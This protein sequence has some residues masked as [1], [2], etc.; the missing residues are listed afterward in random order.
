MDEK[1]T[2]E[3]AS[4]PVTDGDISKTTKVAASSTSYCPACGA[5]LHIEVMYGLAWLVCDRYGNGCV[6]K[7]LA[8]L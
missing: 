5:G 7:R 3:S 6:Y 1:V 4:A 8:P 2:I